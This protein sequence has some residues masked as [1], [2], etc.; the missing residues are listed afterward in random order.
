M[1]AE[2]LKRLAAE[3][4]LDIVGAARAE[5][6]EDTERHIRDRY[7]R[8]LFARM[9]FTMARPDVSCHP[10]A[11]IENA[12]TVVSAALPYYVAEPE[13]QAMN[14]G[15]LARYTWCDEYA[16]LRAK[17]EHLGRRLGGTYRV[18]VDSNDHVDREGAVRAGLGFYGKNTMVI[19]PS[20]GSWV[21]LGALVTDVE[22]E[23]TPQLEL[24]CGACRLCVDAC[25][26]GALDEPGVLDA[27]RCLSYWTQAPAPTPDEYREEFGDRIYGCDV[28]Q[29]VCPW[30]RGAERRHRT[31]SGVA[32]TTSFVSLLDWLERDGDDLVREFDRLYVPRNDPRWLRRN[33]LLAAGNVAGLELEPVIEAFATG[34]DEILRDAAEWALQRIRERVA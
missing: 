30:N 5:A 34:E 27:T 16:E 8:G 10:E 13:P 24:D 4:G 14:S 20:D 15:R 25:P 6:Y 32:T 23:P 28:C 2:E 33:A 29:E 9:R 3:C 31:S 19:T 11:L 22:V 17:L 12:R 21:V 26:T 1:T 18:L 7:A